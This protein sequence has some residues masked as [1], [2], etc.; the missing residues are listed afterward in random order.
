MSLTP[1]VLRLALGCMVALGVLGVGVASAQ[2]MPVPAPTVPA[3]EAGDGVIARWP[4][5]DAP[6]QLIL[7]Q[8]STWSKKNIVA[9]KQV[10]GNISA[11]LFNVTFR[12]ALDALLRVNGFDY[13]EKGNFIYVYTAKEIKEVRKAERKKI[14]RVFT[15][16]YVKPEDIRELLVPFLSEDAVIATSPEVESDI[17]TSD[18]EAGG[19][20][21]AINDVL[22]ISDYEENIKQI[23]ALLKEVDKRPQQVLIEATILRATL[24]EDTALG[25]DFNVLSGVD[26]HDLSA[27]TT[28]VTNLTTTSTDIADI[29]TGIGAVRTDFTAGIPAA[30]GG[31]SFGWIGS[32]AAVFLR[33]LEGVLD[34]TVLANPKL[35]VVNK[36]RGEILVGR[37]DGYIVTTTTE[38]NTSTSVEFLETGTRLV[39]RPYIGRN[40]YIRMVLHPEDSSGSVTDGLPSET[41]TE[42][43]SNVI[44][45]DGRTI[46]ISGLFRE[47]TVNGRSQVPLL[48]NIPYA[49]PLFR[50]TSDSTDREEVIILITPRIIKHGPDEVAS[51]KLRDD[52]ERFRLGMRQHLAWF[53]RG[54]LSARYLD[55]A[56]QHI[57]NGN[58]DKALWDINMALS[59]SPTTLE[60]LEL[61]ERLTGEAIWAH[62]PRMS[63]TRWIV[64]KMILNELGVE[65]NTVS[66]PDKP[67]DANAL[68]PE[69]RDA[70]G[71]DNLPAPPP[72]PEPII[73][74][75]P[76][77]D[78]TPDADDADGSP[79]AEADSSTV[80][81]D[82]ADGSPS[83]EADGSTVEADDADGS[84]SAEADS[85]TVEADEPDGA[86]G[87]E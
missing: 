68:T 15:L 5:Q 87:T 47:I 62:E 63:S 22:V 51:E 20:D 86:T 7:R 23:E 1:R 12:E 76:A 78:V 27:S 61:K 66:T 29:G 16:Y 64:Q 54:R 8:L 56:K 81:A 45:K 72:L 73:V 41:T 60:A 24:T 74:T 49:G 28:G 21:Y 17:A 43:T 75:P 19:M 53:G 26:F 85:S 6:I 84:P 39:V 80:E 36:Q 77:V 46:I 52:I 67:L 57:A 38:T 40:G 31:L 33:A 48:G 44:V 79:S 14:T 13:I 37:R 2:V 55:W 50:R 82:D 10:K 34:T 83:A 69:V 58:R 65:V 30:S 59:L 32:D 25:I 4:F 11:E 3:M 71:I 9:S 70:M 42:C 18:S 35:L